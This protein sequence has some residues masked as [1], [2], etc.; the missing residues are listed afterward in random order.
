M[1]TRA[2]SNL[3]T[4]LM[5]RFVWLVPAV[6]LLAVGAEG[7]VRAIGSRQEVTLTCDSFSRTR[8]TSARL[9]VT[10]C[11]IDYVHAAF[12]ESNG[13][14]TELFFPARP[15]GNNA[16]PLVVAT[17]DRSAVDMAQR[18]IGGGRDATTEQRLTVMHE[19]ADQLQL[20]IGI[21]GALR[22]GLIERVSSRRM[23]SGLAEA[24]A[25]DAAVVDLHGTPDVL[26]SALATAAGLALAMVP[27]LVRKR[28]KATPVAASE[29]LAVEP[30]ISAEPPPAITE[31]TP[32]VTVETA[33]PPTSGREEPAV[34]VML[35]RLLL[36]NVD[37]LS[38]PEAVESAPP[39][40]SPSEVRAILCGVIPDL[41]FGEHTRILERRD[42]S[43]RFD[44]GPHDVI[45]TVVVEV[46]T[47]GGMA[48]LKEVLL[49]TG[50]RTFAPK[51]GLFVT[52]D[53][54]ESLAALAH[55]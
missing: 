42:R 11:E 44:L 25:A 8:P 20:S 27:W 38:G 41:A 54:L 26:L 35:P 43:I 47:E 45:A 7:L 50:W 39:L 48:L 18:V 3:S 31:D 5:F 16:A 1:E 19:I 40:G 53:D 14:I 23:L 28:P 46:H 52:I 10:G 29:P 17:T 49:M 22:A 24:L 32:P 2:W 4:G 37:V 6:A 15:P 9:R 55:E 13:Q 12:R 30:E 34:S 33:A 51:T 36:L 21:D